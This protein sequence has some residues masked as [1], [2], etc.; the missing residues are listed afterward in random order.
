MRKTDGA[1]D[2]CHKRTKEF[3]PEYNATMKEMKKA[4]SNEGEV[5]CRSHL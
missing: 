4:E 1:K 5:W 3:A 2:L